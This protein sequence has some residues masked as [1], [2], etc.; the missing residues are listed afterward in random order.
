MSLKSAQDGI[1]AVI[2]KTNPVKQAAQWSAAHAAS[3]LVKGLTREL[4]EIRSQQK[5][6][7]NA[8]VQISAQLNRRQ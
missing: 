6:I 2:S 8:L 5:E 4:A 3:D 7:M 1:G